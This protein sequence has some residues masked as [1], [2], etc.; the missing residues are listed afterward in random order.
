MLDCFLEFQEIGVLTRKKMWHQLILCHLCLDHSQCW[1]SHANGF[2]PLLRTTSPS[3]N[4]DVVNT[5]YVLLLVSATLEGFAWIYNDTNNICNI[6]LSFSEKKKFLTNILYCGIYTRCA[7]FRRSQA[8]KERSVRRC[9]IIHTKLMKNAE[10]IFGLVHA[11][12]RGV[13]TKLYS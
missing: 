12:T 6:W 4:T 3:L 9:I 10:G 5:K 2:P 13:S 1:Y 11:W 7:C 8:F